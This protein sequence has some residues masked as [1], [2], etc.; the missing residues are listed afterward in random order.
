MDLTVLVILVA[1]GIAAIVAA[2]HLTGG[3]ET[4]RLAD[5][6]AAVARFRLDHPEAEIGRVHLAN[7]GQ[8]A[9][10]ELA[11]GGTGIVQAFGAHFLTRI[12]SDA[13]VRS[14][15]RPLDSRLVLRLN[16]LTWPGGTF[17]FT[18][19]D[20]AEAVAARLGRRARTRTEEGIA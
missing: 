19:A 17:D 16:D 11:D 8:A 18:D 12:V 6:E 3:S 13:D 9:F 4:A 7:A 14:L 1:G 10:L 2:V 20:S 5:A 15:E